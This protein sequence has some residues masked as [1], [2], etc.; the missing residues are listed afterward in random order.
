[1]H[2]PERVRVLI[3][4]DDED[5]FVMARDLLGAQEHTPCDVEWASDPDEAL[6]VI[7]ERRH[8]VYLLD[9]RLGGTTGLELLRKAFGGNTHAPAIM[10]TGFDDHAVDLEATMLGVTDFLIKDGLDSAQL[11]RSIRYAVRHHAVLSELRETQERYSLAVRGANDGIWDWDL[12]AG[13]VYYGS[14]W[15]E[16]LGHSEMEIGDSPDEWFERVYDED[17]ARVHAA[18]D[19]H[20]H[21]HAAHF[22]SEHRIRHADGSYRWIFSRGVAVRDEQGTAT[23]MAGSISDVTDRKAATERLRHD[24]RHD[25]L[26]GLPNRTMFLDRL[27]MALSQSKRHPSYRCAVLFLDLNRFKRI[28]DAFGHAMGD[29]VLTA[30]ARRLEKA[31]REGDTVARLG[32]DEF[33]VLLHDIESV[34]AAWDVAKRIQRMVG[35]PFAT[36]GRSLTVTT[37]IGITTSQPGSDATELMNNADIAMYEAKIGTDEGT[38]LFTASMRER[39]VGH[40]KVEDELRDAIDGERLRVFYQP[41]VDIERGKLTGL[42][43]LARWPSEAE[44]DVSPIEFIPVAEDTGLIRPLGRIVLREACSRLSEWRADGLVDDD[45]TMSVNVSG[46]QLGEVGLLEDVAVALQDSALPAR[47]LRLEITEGT[48][49]RD[50]ERMPAAL[51]ELDELGV[52]AHID[53]FGTGY[54]SLTF[55]R[56]FAGNTVK[57][58]R[59]FISSIYADDGSAEIV[60]TIIGLAHNL[61]LAVI[62][63]GVETEEQ[64]RKLHELGGRYAQGF[65][66]AEPLDATEAKELLTAWEPRDVAA[67]AAH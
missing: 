50:P 14:R 30:V 46:C 62:A 35:K 20:L 34:E 67:Y 16:I 38:A 45:V 5:D 61:D 59:S 21:G 1:M 7:G 3:V 57:I 18:I 63:E 15:K 19:A 8:D 40:L 39:V 55:L 12:V 41:I 56:H 36:M 47:A 58:D 51:D 32:G 66:F 6:R 25:S 28:N 9:H 37:S 29:R 11:E 49:M 53:D 48:I 13:S 64:L 60:R 44:R 24:A 4:D 2:I 42:E 23:R 33:T 27:E 54:S 10:L 17:L 31:M 43:A 26:T 65:L 52:G 22:E